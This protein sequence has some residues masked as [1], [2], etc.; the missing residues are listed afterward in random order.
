M[1][2]FKTTVSDL[3]YSAFPKSSYLRYGVGESNLI[4]T[5]P[6]GGNTKPFFFPRRKFGNQLMD[7]YTRRLTEKIINNLD[8]QPYYIVSDIHRSRVDL[9]RTFLEGCERNPK[10]EKVWNSWDKALQRYTNEITY[11]YDK[12][13]YIDIH[14]HNNGDYFQLGYNLSSSDYIKLYDELDVSG[15]SLDSLD[16]DLREMVF[17]KYSFKYS[18]ED[19]GYEIFFPTKNE[20]YFNGGRNIEVYSGN[21][22]GSVQIE[23]PVSILKYELDAVAFAL[24]ESIIKFQEKF[25]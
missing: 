9:N 6:H 17:G 12:G 5:A 24:S 14:S 8:V 16:Y 21:G 18:L 3:F 15:S 25:T 19:F 23:C 4:I 11:E 13:L 20:Q 7:S 2:S 22:I 10:A 1:R